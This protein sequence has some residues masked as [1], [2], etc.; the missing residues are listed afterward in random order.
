MK[1]GNSTNSLRLVFWET[2]SACNLRCVHCR[3]CPVEQR[4]PDD[5]STDEAKAFIDQVSSF[6]SPILVL[7]GG[8]PLVR[9]DILDLAAYG[10]SK[11]LR[12]ALATN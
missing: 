1:N 7:S 9:E 6:A 5:L 8:E 12:I 11:G 2:T 3:A 4:S 10:H